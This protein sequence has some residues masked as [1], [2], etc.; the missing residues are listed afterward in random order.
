MLPMTVC[1]NGRSWLGLVQQKEFP[2]T[3]STSRFKLIGG[4]LAISM[5]LQPTTLMAFAANGDTTA[6]GHSIDKPSTIA[7]L[8][9]PDSKRFQS[10]ETAVGLRAPE[11]TEESAP[12]VESDNSLAGTGLSSIGPA[13][14]DDS[15]GHFINLSDLAEGNVKP[16]D[17][18][19]LTRAEILKN[20]NPLGGELL[21]RADLL[22]AAS[23]VTVPTQVLNATIT[24]DPVVAKS[25]IDDL[26]RQILL[27]EVELERFNLHYKQ[28]VAKQGRWKG[29]RYAML[30]EVNGALNLTGGII[31]TAERGSHLEK[32]GGHIA[33]SIHTSVQ[34]NANILPLI[35]NCIGALAALN[36]FGVNEYHEIQ[37]NRHGYGS[38][39]ARRHVDGLRNDIDRLLNERA[40]NLQVERTAT[41]LQGHA[42]V[43]DAEGKVL[44]DMRD[45]G[46]LEFQRFHISA[47]RLLAFQQTQ[48]FFDFAKYTTN[49]IGFEFAFLA[50][51]KHHR[52][53]NLRAGVL[54]EVSGALYMMGP[55]ISRYVGKAVA[56]GHRHYLKGTIQ[57]AEAAKVEDLTKD[58]AT[59]DELCRGTQ[60][61]EDAASALARANIYA[62]QSKVFQD[63]LQASTKERSKAKLTA[64]QNIGSGLF[65]GSC[66]VASGVLFNVVGGNVHYRGTTD[67]AGRVTNANLFAA[68]VVML[69]AITYSMLD[70]LRIQ[71]QGESNRHKQMEAG[72]HPSQLITA[73]LAQLDDI[74]RRLGGTPPAATTK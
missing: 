40:A 69:P 21:E 47:R 50:L 33:G 63:E 42:A 72:T 9:T 36:E 61:S 45:Q 51:H 17:D 74:Q 19:L 43:D 53:W 66:K 55:I 2:V 37:A 5:S 49:A 31:S 73:R 56:E 39:A 57:E 29:W 67:R 32:N 22:A 1:S 3:T 18:D 58:K 34:Q 44:A 48:Y 10:L 46:M 13:L 30:Q 28:E 68:S 54:F 59:L 27:K 35:G 52:H 15:S 16:T 14:M 11:P 4:L 60:S 23:P 24:N 70:T 8:G 65:V 38:G 25:R 12:P 62:D 26:T 7:Y 6:S 41:A 64:T 71:V 20:S